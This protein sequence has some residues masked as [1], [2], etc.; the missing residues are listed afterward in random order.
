M[1][2]GMCGKGNPYSLLVG[3]DTGSAT[4]EI[5]TEKSQKA[6]TKSTIWPT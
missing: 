3:L 1:L 4:I 5:S 6:K 2:E